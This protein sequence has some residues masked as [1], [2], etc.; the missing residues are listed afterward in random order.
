MQCFVTFDLQVFVKMTDL[1]S[2]HEWVWPKEKFLNRK[3]VMQEMYDKFEDD[4]DWKMA[5]V[6]YL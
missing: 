1:E 3:F 6:S 2:G 5:A 4:E